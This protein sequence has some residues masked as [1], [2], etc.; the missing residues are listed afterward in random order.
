MKQIKVMIEGTG[1]Q[2]DLVEYMK[3]IVQT[4]FSW[5]EG[6]W[7]WGNMNGPQQWKFTTEVKPIDNG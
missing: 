6:V 2:E 7:D 1:T 3:A 4:Q 5:P